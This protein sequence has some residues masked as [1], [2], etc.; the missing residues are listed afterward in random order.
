MNENELNEIS[1]KLNEY[2]MQAYG[3]DF[4]KVYK[5]GQNGEKQSIKHS[6]VENIGGLEVSRG[7][8]PYIDYLKQ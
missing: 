3:E 4:Y 6:D 8:S 2:H 1:N 7:Y 5:A